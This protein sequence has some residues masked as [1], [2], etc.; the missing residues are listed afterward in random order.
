[1]Q[2]SFKPGQLW[3]DNNGVHINAHGGGLLFHNGIYYWFGEHKLPGEQGNV[4]DVGVHVYTSADLYN[5]TDAGIALRVVD[6]QK[7]EIARGCILERP[8]VL[9]NDSTGRFVMWFHLELK[10]HG[11]KSARSGIAVADSPTGPYQYLGSVRPNAAVAPWSV[12]EVE[13]DATGPFVRDFPIGQMARD[14]ALFKDDDG[15]AYH[16]FASEENQTL[17]ISQ[18]TNDYLRPAGIFS[19]VHI[20][21]YREAP[22]IL[23]Y[24]GK[25]YLF[26]SACS[27]WAP[28]AAMVSVADTIFGPYEELGNPCVGAKEQRET[29]FGAQS[30]FV[31]P[32]DGNPESFIFLADIWRPKDAIDGR[33]VWLPIRFANGMPLVEWHDEWDLGVF[34]ATS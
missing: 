8:K 30:T 21:Q 13:L 5:W 22:A 4:A 26:T 27:G 32:V 9:Y 19:R 28:N 3:P 11:Y 18:I 25:Y 16:I 23:K 10:G 34:K 12:P 15:S 33:Y 29:T 20:G 14:M 7:S 17:H 2:S 31:L 1:M 24:N 6:D